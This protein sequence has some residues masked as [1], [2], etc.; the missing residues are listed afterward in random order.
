MTRSR[1]RK[2]SSGARVW[3]SKYPGFR[4]S[5]RKPMLMLVTEDS[6]HGSRQAVSRGII[7]Q[8]YRRLCGMTPRADKSVIGPRWS[9]W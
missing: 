7:P 1:A 4:G 9:L 5:K 3:R 8:R 6:S 2:L